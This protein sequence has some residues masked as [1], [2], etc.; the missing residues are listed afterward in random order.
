MVKCTFLEIYGETGLQNTQIMRG[1]GRSFCNGMV[2]TNEC[3]MNAKSGMINFYCD[4]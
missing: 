2:T 1:Q 3:K 4:G